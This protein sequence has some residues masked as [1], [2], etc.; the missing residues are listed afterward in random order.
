MQVEYDPIKAPRKRRGPSKYE[1]FGEPSV[2]AAFAVGTVHAVDPDSVPMQKQYPVVW[3]LAVS[4]NMGRFGVGALRIA[5]N[6]L[7][8]EANRLD[9]DTAVKAAYAAR[10][11]LW[12][13]ILL[14]GKR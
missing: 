7:Y 10:N 9:D 12:E 14:R 5:H 4:R 11:A 2:T 8:D 3:C 1:T 13:E 6:S